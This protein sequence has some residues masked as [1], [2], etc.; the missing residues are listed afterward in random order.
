M[1]YGFCVCLELGVGMASNWILL[2]WCEMW[3]LL[4]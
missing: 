3:E 4:Y 1:V 2:L